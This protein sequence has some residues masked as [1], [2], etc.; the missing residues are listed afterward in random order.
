M[1]IATFNIN[2]VSFLF[3]NGS[4]HALI[5]KDWT[6]FIGFRS[7]GTPFEFLA[8]PEPSISSESHRFPPF[9]EAFIQFDQ[10]VFSTHAAYMLRDL[11]AGGVE[12]CR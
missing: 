12:A 11:K 1:R 10:R 5:V 4:A 2:N 7:M 6:G 3:F 8:L 9:S